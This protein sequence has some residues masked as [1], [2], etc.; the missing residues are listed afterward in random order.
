QAQPTIM[1]EELKS[2]LYGALHYFRQ[3]SIHLAKGK[4]AQKAYNS[5][6]EKTSALPLLLLPL[7]SLARQQ[8]EQRG[9]KKLILL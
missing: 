4:D 8:T 2:S 1:S 9:V 3:P 7:R 6:T 5:L